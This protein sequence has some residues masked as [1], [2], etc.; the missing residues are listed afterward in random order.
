M[1]VYILFSIAIA[2]FAIIFAFQ[3]SQ[4]I[5]VS[6]LNWSF[7]GSLALVILV[8]VAGGVLMSSLA[9]LPPLFKTRWTVRSQRKT[10]AELESRIAEQS[11]RLEAADQK[12]VEPQRKEPP[13][14]PGSFGTNNPVV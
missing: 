9:S 6:F 14:P 10:I 13:A 3:N 5:T 1:Q 2:I 12:N 7:T 11:R 8:S 4:L